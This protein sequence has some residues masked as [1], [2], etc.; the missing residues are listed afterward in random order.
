MSTYW[1]APTIN[2]KQTT[3]NG[4]ITSGQNTITLNSTANMQYPGYIIVDRQDSSGTNTSAFREVITYTG[5]SGN[6]LT[7]C[8]RGAD[9]SSPLA[10]NDGA[11][12]ET[13]PTVGMW[14]SLVTIVSSAIDP[15]GALN[16]FVS[17]VSL[18]YINTNSLLVASIASIAQLSISNLN[19]SGASVLGMGLSPVFTSG[20]QYSGPTVAIGGILVAPRPATLQWVSAFTRYVVSGASVGFDF[21]LRNASIFANAT[22]LPAIAAGGTFVST[23]SIGTKNVNVGDMLQADIASVGA[24]GNVLQ[25][26]IQAG[27]L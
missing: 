13:M 21:K 23:A 25:V 20:A 17:P 26:T 7:G 10:H 22:S 18:G 15:S 6:V 27:S 2:Y 5:I 1:L 11:V 16:A 14:N 4:S 19:V 12:V 24:T 9:N 8:V 3:L